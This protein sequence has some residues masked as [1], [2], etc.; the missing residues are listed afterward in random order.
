MQRRMGGRGY[1][2]RR[3]LHREKEALNTLSFIAC[4]EPREIQ[5]L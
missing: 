3:S 1:D 2:V 4:Q 5:K